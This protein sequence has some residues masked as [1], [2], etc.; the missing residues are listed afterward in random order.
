M[1][2]LTGCTGEIGGPGAGGA[3]E[4]PGAEPPRGAGSSG[5]CGAAAHPL[6]RL[7]AV[8]LGNTLRDLFPWVALPPPGLPEDPRPS[9]FDNDV[10]GLTASR[11]FV[12]AHWRHVQEVAAR[13]APG[14][15]AE[16]G[17][18]EDGGDLRGCAARFVARWTLPVLRR[19]ADPALAEELTS[20]FVEAWGEA[21]SAAAGAEVALAAM[22]TFPEFVY[23]VPEA[24]GAGPGSEEDGITPGTTGAR[25]AAADPF[26]VASRLSY[27]IWGSLPDEPLFAAAQAGALAD[28]LVLRAEAERM[29]EDPRARRGVRHFFA[30]WLELEMLEEA[31]RPPETGWDGQLRELMVEETLQLVEHLVFETDGTFR[32]LLTTQETFLNGRLA[33]HYGVAG[34]PASDGFRR[35]TFEEPRPGVLTRGAF[36][37][38]HAHSTFPSPVFRG[39]YVVRD[40]LCV[41]LG[42]PPPNAETTGP[43]DDGVGARTNR[44]LY[45]ARTTAAGREC[46]VCHVLINP[47]GFALEHYDE[48][49]RYRSLDQ[50]QP[51]DGS[52]TLGALDL[53]FVD[54]TELFD[55]LADA[56]D[57]ARCFVRKLARFAYGGDPRAT[58][59]CLLDELTARALDADMR[60]REVFLEVVSHPETLRLASHAPMDDPEER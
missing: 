55:G 57:A 1:A 2:A 6:R 46:A 37:V 48:L 9:G 36:L 17:C 49:G 26:T 29:M 24:D 59:N 10:D 5:T 52:G 20:L 31:T 7:S 25:D 58:E 43:V 28:P 56:D 38:G 18:S 53:A 16:A 22:L 54:A 41:N 45:E 30:Q 23:L 33:A 40:L 32:E 14:A 15:L 8:E 11:A 4:G 51:V 19:P 35:H 34:G 27:A 47:P 3:R 60:L 50:G 13:A 42:S 39:H 21:G 44:E 12:E